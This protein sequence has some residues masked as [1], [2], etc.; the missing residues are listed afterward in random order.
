MS[1]KYFKNW[2]NKWEVYFVEFISV[3]L[4]VIL[5]FLLNSWRSDHKDEITKNKILLEITQGLS[6]DIAD[7]EGNIKAHKRA[8]KSCD[9]WRAILNNKDFD[10]EKLQDNYIYTFRDYFILENKS[11]YE[12]L[13]SKGLELIQNDSLRNKIINVYEYDFYSLKML[14]ENYAECQFH[15]SYF[16]SFNDIIAPHFVFSPENGEIINI[17]KPLNLS[18]EDRNILM[19]Y[20]MKIETNRKFTVAYY[21]EKMNNIN[22][23][24]DDIIEVLQYN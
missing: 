5:A 20:L 17:N 1:G 7:M 10:P 19:S 3:F 4:A 23:L 22:S 12:T 24:R 8:I 2:K 11:G 18:V 21:S 9:F 13:Q 14:E 16:N 15:E 6:K